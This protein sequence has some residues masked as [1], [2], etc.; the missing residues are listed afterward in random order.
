MKP[1]AFEYHAPSTLR[2]ALR[3]LADLQDQASVLA[4]GQSL[5]PMLNLR[6]ARPA[7]VVDINGIPRLD[8]LTNRNG[9]LTLG[10]LVRQRQ[11]ERSD[12]VRTHCP[13]L[14]EALPLIGHPQIR[15]RGTVAGSLAHADPR[16]ELPLVMVLLEPTLVLRRLGGQRVLEPAE[17]F[18]GRLKT[19]CRPDEL[20]TEVRL[21]RWP[22][23]AGWAYQAVSR[24]QGDLALVA[25][26]AVVQRAADSTIADARLGFAGVADIPLRARATEEALRGAR[27]S[28]ELLATMAR[29][30][31]AALQPADDVLASGSYRQYAAGVLAERALRTALQRTGGSV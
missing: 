21:P 13:L 18:V 17:F 9:R 8:Q 27:P 2:E 20:L 26:A 4:G 6:H 1:P 16:A 7:H 24:R 29:Q 3:L 22:A 14:A 30:A 10:A 31:A 25:A 23:G 15:S 11:A 19:A 5:V 12:L 28:A